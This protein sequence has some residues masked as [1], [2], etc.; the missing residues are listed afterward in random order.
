MHEPVALS[1][2]VR[3]QWLRQAQPERR[4]YFSAPDLQFGRLPYL[5]IQWAGLACA[6]CFSIWM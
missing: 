2:V 5:S 3:L 1:W 6:L 4:E